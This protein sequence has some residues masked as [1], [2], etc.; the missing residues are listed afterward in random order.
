MMK[1]RS[2]QTTD[3]PMDTK[4][5]E[6]LAKEVADLELILHH[7]L[8]DKGNSQY[9]MFA[10]YHSGRKVRQIIGQRG[11]PRKFRDVH[12]AI[13]WGKDSGF[14]SVSL[15]ILYDGYPSPAQAQQDED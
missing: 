10:T 8:D 13:D 14:K 6:E 1:A 12:R 3:G 2:I 7:E 5:L 15:S 9:I 11:S 4:I